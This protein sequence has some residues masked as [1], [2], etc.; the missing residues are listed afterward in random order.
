MKIERIDPRDSEWE[1]DRPAYRV[2]FWHQPPAP[3]GKRQGQ[4]AYHSDEYR[5][6]GA[7]DVHEVLTWAA[8]TAR[9]EQTFTLYIERVEDGSPGLIHLAGSDPTEDV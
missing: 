1:D 7:V 6:R 5:L 4:V 3:A 9:P 2:Y 8:D